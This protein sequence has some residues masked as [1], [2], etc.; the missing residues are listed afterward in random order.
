MSPLRLIA[1]VFAST[2]LAASAEPIQ[3]ELTGLEEVPVVSST[4]S[5]SF[6]AQIDDAAGTVSYVLRY[7]GLEGSVQQAHVH[8]G[9]RSANGGIAVFLC[10]NLADP[11]P[12]TPGCPTPAGTVSGV[13]QA[14]D[15]IGPSSQGIAS[16]EFDELLRAIRG[17][18]AYVNIHSTLVPAGEIRGQLR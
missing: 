2:P 15:V 4:G 17:G 8:M 1:F 5:G 12:G 6:Q 16:G 18:A 9:Q 11:P 7:S 14:G 13:F 3:A 10:S